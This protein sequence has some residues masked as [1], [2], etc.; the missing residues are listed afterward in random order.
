EKTV[1]VVLEK[2]NKLYPKLPVFGSGKSFGG[3]MSSQRMSMEGLDFVKGLIFYGFP[4]HAPGAASIDRAAH[5]KTV[6]VPM[7]F[8]QGTRDALA[9]LKL[10]TKVTDG[11]KLASLVTLEGADHSFKAGKQDLIPMLASITR[12]WISKMRESKA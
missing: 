8:L 5:L 9:D 11:L 6:K 2:A 1:E 3:R 4:L 10:V 7:L 12:E